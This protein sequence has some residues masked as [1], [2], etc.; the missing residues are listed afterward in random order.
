MQL[1]ISEFGSGHRSA[2]TNVPGKIY[3]RSTYQVYMQAI[4][5]DISRMY[6]Q[7]RLIHFQPS[8]RIHSSFGTPL[9][10]QC[11]RLALAF[12]FA[13]STSSYSQPVPRHNQRVAQRPCLILLLHSNMLS[14]SNSASPIRNETVEG[15]SS[16]QCSVS[17]KGRIFI[18]SSPSDHQYPTR[19]SRP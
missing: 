17:L 18:H 14:E 2:P 1:K 11:F 8:C 7:I 12:L 16:V 9:P 6:C 5:Y 15:E 13:I 10:H 4:H 19:C 3:T